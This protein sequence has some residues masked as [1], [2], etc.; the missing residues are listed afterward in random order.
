MSNKVPPTVDVTETTGELFCPMRWIGYVVKAHWAIVLQD[1]VLDGV[2][3]WFLA[4]GQ[5]CL[6][7]HSTWHLQRDTLKVRDP[8]LTYTYLKHSCPRV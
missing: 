4:G 6:E 8:F 1:M 2:N 7:Y 3:Q 5:G